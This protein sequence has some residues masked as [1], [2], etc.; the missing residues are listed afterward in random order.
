M[1]FVGLGFGGF[2]LFVYPFAWCFFCAAEHA[3]TGDGEL[4][5]EFGVGF[6][7]QHDAIEFPH[8]AAAHFAF[9]LVC[10]EGDEAW[11]VAPR[12]RGAI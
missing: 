8:H 12:L 10:F 9:G 7:A 5:G 6:D 11:D 2:D 3:P 4:F 1:F